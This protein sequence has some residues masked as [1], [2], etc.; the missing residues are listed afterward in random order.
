MHNLEAKVKYVVVITTLAQRVF[1]HLTLNEVLIAIFSLL[2][3]LPFYHI[4]ITLLSLSLSL[5]QGLYTFMVHQTLFN[6]FLLPL[7]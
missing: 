3:F 7:C 6:S 2:L 5:S 4:Y 1:L